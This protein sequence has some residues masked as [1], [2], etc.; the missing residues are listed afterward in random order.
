MLSGKTEYLEL[1]ENVNWVSQAMQVY[2]QALSSGL[3]PSLK[4]LDRMLACLRLPYIPAIASG[5][6]SSD[7]PFQGHGHVAEL[8]QQGN[9]I[10]FEAAAI[11]ILEEAIGLGVLPPFRSVAKGAA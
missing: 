7:L 6:M 8:G 2:R 4:T 3:K 5:R 10:A 1:P 9:D 11:P